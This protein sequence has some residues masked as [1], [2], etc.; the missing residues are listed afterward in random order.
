[1]APVGSVDIMLLDRLTITRES[2]EDGT[3]W[4]LN[5]EG[6]C[7]GEVCIPLSDPIGDEVDVASMSEQMNMPLVHDPDQDLWSLGPWTGGGRAL[8]SAEAPELVLP[9]VNGDEFRLSSLLGQKVL[10]LS[11]APY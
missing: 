8:V 1:M 6:A 9:D 11:W 7:R 3:G 10:I 2:F 5:P 4:Q